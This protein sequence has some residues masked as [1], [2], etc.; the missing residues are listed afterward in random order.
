MNSALPSLE[1]RSS[2]GYSLTT[3]TPVEGRTRDTMKITVDRDSCIKAG[4]CY[5]N[6]KQL[7]K[8]DKDGYP[9]VLVEEVTSP[10]DIAAAEEA[11]MGC[12]TNAI[13]LTD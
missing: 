12:P 7:F 13:I 5:S 11:A 3:N 9:V 4:E 2:F 6:F 10:E 1:P 8:V